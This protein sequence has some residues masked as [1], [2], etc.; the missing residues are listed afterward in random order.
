MRRAGLLLLMLL[1]VQAAWAIGGGW[2]L[3]APLSRTHVVDAL[4]WDGQRFWAA[5]DAGSLLTSADGLDWSRQESGTDARLHALASNADGVRV[6]VGRTGAVVWDDGSGVWSPARALTS[7]DLLAVASDGRGFVAVG[8]RGAILKSPD[9]RNWSLRDY[10]AALARLSLRGV[11]WHA[12]R[13]LV[14]GDAG[15][16][17]ESRDGRDWTPVAASLSA[18]LTAIVWWEQG[19]RWLIGTAVGDV[20]ESGDGVHWQAHATGLGQ[21]VRAILATGPEVF[22]TAARGGLSHSADLL[23][24][25]VVT[26]LV[27][28]DLLAIADNGSRLLAM[29]E[30]A[31][32]VYS[33][34]G[35]FTWR[36]ARPPRDDLLSVV[37]NGGQWFVAVGDG[38]RIL[39]SPDGIDWTPV[40]SPTTR[41]LSA[42]AWDAASQSFWAVGECGVL[43]RGNASADTWTGIN[44]TGACHDPTKADPPQPPSARTGGLVSGRDLNGVVVAGAGPA[45]R[46]VAVGDWGTIVDSADGSAWSWQGIQQVAGGTFLPAVRPQALRDV[47]WNG[48]LYVA[49]GRQGT[50]VTSND[51]RAWIAGD[52]GTEAPLDS[53]I[54][55]AGTN[56]WLV[57]GEGVLLTSVDGQTWTLERSLSTANGASGNGLARLLGEAVVATGDYVAVGWHGAVLE[58]SNGLDW[59]TVETG[60]GDVRLRDVTAA[61]Q[62]V[63][64]VG[65]GGVILVRGDV[66]DLVVDGG[67]STP[68]IEGRTGEWRL[69]VRNDGPLTASAVTATIELPADLDVTV[70]PTPSSGLCQAGPEAGLWRC[71]LGDLPAAGRVEIVFDTVPARAGTRIVVAK[72][73]TAAAEVDRSDNAAR[74]RAVVTASLPARVAVGPRLGGG[75]T[76]QWGLIVLLAGL[77]SVRRRPGTKPTRHGTLS[78]DISLIR[79]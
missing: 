62:A 57:G 76:L 73:S 13:W 59:T 77:A 1:A 65:D 12:G 4:F 8:T 43:I 66:S 64:A 21:P 17:L 27:T 32:A 24:W 31:V 51:G 54:W 37:S 33:D 58:S 36:S 6:A 25:T 78:L 26:P 48:L 63:V 50:I 56:R 79:C 39:R 72:A 41:R 23:L 29:G 22:V 53:V 67:P 5:G 71:N 60:L 34:D 16:L 2:R 18:D 47:A 11:A 75:G 44:P 61:G 45:S 35:G 40:P 20:L 10:P 14:V 42:I 30:D 15:V 9:G 69:T 19:G 52:S 68:L 28:D 70:A 46:I 7:E 3:A 74:I 49:V 38:G 55:D